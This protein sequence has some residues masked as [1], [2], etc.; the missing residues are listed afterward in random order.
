MTL[1]QARR[2]ASGFAL[3]MV[4]FLLFAVAIGGLTGYQVVSVEGTLASG[5][6]DSEV[7]LITAHAG[8]QRYVAE[9]IGE[10]GPRT[11]P[12][13][14]G[15]VTVTPRRVAVLNDSTELYLLEAVGTVTDPSNPTHPAT[16][17]LR[18]YA[19][20]NTMPLRPV[21]ALIVIEDTVEFLSRWQVA[22][23]DIAEAGDC[24]GVPGARFSTHGIAGTGTNGSGTTQADPA[25][26]RVSPDRYQVGGSAA[27]VIAAAEVRWS[28]LQDPG[29][30]IGVYNDVMPDFASLPSDSFPIVRMNGD[31]YLNQSGRGALIV[32]GIL[33]QGEDMDWR[34]IVL[35][36]QMNNGTSLQRDAGS[37]SEVRGVLAAGLDGIQN[38][39]GNDLLVERFEVLHNPCYVRKANRSIA[40]MT[41][42]DGSRWDF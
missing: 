6:G 27:A 33:T 31:Y 25:N 13:G 5:T 1:P 34:G 37:K 2:D 26:D 20:L 8:L 11:W 42:L 35:V 40:Y 10:P 32:T 19:Y 36:G 21:A 4:V 18:Q 9:H 16:R 12:I 39:G 41:L 29:F 30:G 22:G 23:N 38:F 17:T 3:A 15:S 28:V 24:I 14:G 7:A